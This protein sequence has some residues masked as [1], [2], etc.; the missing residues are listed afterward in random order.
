[1][2]EEKDTSPGKPVAPLPAISKDIREIEASEFDIDVVQRSRTTPVVVCFGAPWSSP[3]RAVLG[4]L[5][6]LAHEELKNVCFLQV[7]V[8]RAPGLARRMSVRTIPDVRA[9]DDGVLVAHF[10]G[11]L[12]ETLVRRSLEP[13]IRSPATLHSLQG[14]HAFA[15]GRCDEAEA[16]YRLALALD[17]GHPAALLGLGRLLEER[18]DVTGAWQMYER[19]ALDTPQ[20]RVAGLRM[21]LLADTAR[22]MVNSRSC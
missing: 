18:D 21:R 2:I 5:E 13:V 7:N 8:D 1:M 16:E 4:T 19:I 20:H 11:H 22:R 14:L 3:S 17:S 6:A 12:P 9:Y 10:V 15:A